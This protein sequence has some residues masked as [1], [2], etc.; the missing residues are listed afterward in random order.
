MF[1]WTH[2]EA[3]GIMTRQW[4]LPDTFAV[5]IEN[6]TE[7]DR[8][9]TQP[10]A[11][12]DDLAVAMSA[13]L[14]TAGD[15]IWTECARFEDCYEKVRPSGSPTTRDLLARTD[16]DFADFAPVLKIAPPAKSLVD[17]YDEAVSQPE[18]TVAATE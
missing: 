2:A 7:V 3:A 15:P 5:L 8:W 11:T 1:G 10:D 13:L 6:H 9:I 4:N 14:P 16:Q 17:C 12:P 18:E